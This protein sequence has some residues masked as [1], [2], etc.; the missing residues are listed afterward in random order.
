MS[1]RS[2]F[3]SSLSMFGRPS[4]RPAARSACR[5]AFRPRLEA[6][7]DRSLPSVTTGWSTVLGGGS[8]STTSNAVATDPAGNVYVMGSYG[9]AKYSRS[10]A[11]QWDV[12]GGGTA[13][14]VDSSGTN[15]YVVGGSQV[16]DLDP[17]TGASK[18]TQNLSQPSWTSW[19]WGCAVA[20]DASGN[21]YVV[22]VY[23][24]NLLGTYQVSYLT[25][26]DASGNKQWQE[27]YSS[28]TGVTAMSVATATVGGTVN[29]YVSGLFGST[30]T[31]AT[32]SGN[33]S[34]KVASTS[35]FVV[36]VTGSNQFVW[37]KDF[38]PLS[39]T[40]GG[41]FWNAYLAADG[42][43]NVY[44]SG[45]F[46]GLVNFANSNKNSGSFVRNGTFSGDAGSV[47]L[48]KMD[49]NG[50]VVWVQQ[51]TAQSSNSWADVGN[52]SSCIAVDGSGAVYLAG[53]YSGPL[54][55]NPAGG[56]TLSGS[57]SFVTKFDTNGNFQ[58]AASGPVSGYDD[59]IAVDSFGE[60]DV[61]ASNLLWQLQQS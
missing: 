56:G 5:P 49:H 11:F 18:W 51:I 28:N 2:W 37:A 30:A 25:K 8:S 3:R 45:N 42:S 55:F 50:N 38:Q 21:A 41:M 36:D 48:T 19:S 33:G 15:V 60:V 17:A 44:V 27:T 40:S 23:R 16:A 39:G 6:L 22:S 12:S 61:T 52:S 26:F 43:G 14:A 35:V 20:A 29:V 4:G 47:Y 31:F 32:A 7:E 9:V 24:P 46:E 59:G 54:S 1:L 34:L 53:Y 10:G 13:I 58:W 57:G